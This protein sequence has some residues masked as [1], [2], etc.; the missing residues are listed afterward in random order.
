[1]EDTLQIGF[2][3]LKGFFIIFRNPAQW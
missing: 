3:N 2:R 1:M